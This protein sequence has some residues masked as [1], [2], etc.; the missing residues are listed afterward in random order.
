MSYLDTPTVVRQIIP[1]QPGYYAVRP[2][3][4][5]DATVKDVVIEPIVA[6]K[7]EVLV[8]PDRTKQTDGHDTRP[9]VATGAYS[10]NTTYA[11]L[12]PDGKYYEGG[13][14]KYQHGFGDLDAL[15][16]HWNG[17]AAA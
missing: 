3:W 13:G 11:I 8:Y 10:T 17:E 14:E 9:M 5:K 16:A 4:N 6:W 15:V 7:C 1:A 12:H 2:L